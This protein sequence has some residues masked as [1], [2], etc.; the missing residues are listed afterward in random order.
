M[1][2]QGAITRLKTQN[3]SG[4]L[5]RLHMGA[6]E[7]RFDARDLTETS[8]EELHIGQAVEFDLVRG[9][10]GLRATHIRLLSE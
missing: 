3:S 9:P 5:V 10:A 8:F 4:Y 2:T 1:V 6:R 7:I